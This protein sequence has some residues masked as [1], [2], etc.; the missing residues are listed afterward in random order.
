MPLHW[1]Q[2]GYS[3]RA[4]AALADIRIN[5]DLDSIRRYGS[6]GVRFRLRIELP[7][8]TAI[9]ETGLP[10]MRAAQERAAALYAATIHLEFIRVTGG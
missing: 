7:D 3:A 2:R 9:V 6:S 5:A 1:R 10:S 4:D 8:G